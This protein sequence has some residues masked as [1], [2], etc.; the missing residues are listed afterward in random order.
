MSEITFTGNKKLK[1][2][3]RE[4]STKYPYL[5]LRFF[6][7]DG[8]VVSWEQTHASVRG[9]KSASELSTN[10]GMNVGTFESRYEAAFGSRV[11][12]MYQKNGRNYQSLADSNSMSLN[13]YNTWVKNNGG[14]EIM[15]AEPSWF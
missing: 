8:K 15:K 3:A 10:A 13:E 5:F 1:S 14:A 11:E 2:I 12:I 9:K 4:W 6:D 7:A